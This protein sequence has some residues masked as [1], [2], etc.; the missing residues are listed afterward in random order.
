MEF[1]IQFERDGRNPGLDK[2]HVHLQCFAVWELEGGGGEVGWRSAAALT[3]DPK[4]E[5]LATLSTTY[6]SKVQ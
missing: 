6:W 1:E 4:A 2:F 5:I 3:F